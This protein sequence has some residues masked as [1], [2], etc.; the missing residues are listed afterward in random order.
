MVEFSGIS[1][2]LDDVSASPTSPSRTESYGPVVAATLW[3]YAGP[4]IFIIGMCGNVLVLAVMSQR[5]MRGTSTCVYLCWMASADLCVLVS[6]MITEW[7]EAL[8]QVVFKELDEHLC[9]LEKFMFYT[10][11]DT[12]IWICVAF[13]V[14]RFIA[15]CFPLQHRQSYFSAS[16]AKYCALAAFTAAVAKNFHVFWTRGAEFRPT[17][18]TQLPELVSNCGRPTDD[19]R[20]FEFYVRPWI[21]FAVVFAAPFCVIVFCNFF[22]IKAMIR[23]VY[24]QN[25]TSRIKQVN[26]GDV[27][28]I[29]APFKFVFVFLSNYFTQP[30]FHDPYH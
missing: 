27:I 5:R 23:S 24:L 30:V 28:T 10:S 9:K 8:F 1:T 13:T 4:C 3:V 18:A 11:S 7:V 25:F 19:Y 2:M 21:A 22:I 17:N 14:D 29:L 12:S 20:H 15:V 26:D 6:G 16:N